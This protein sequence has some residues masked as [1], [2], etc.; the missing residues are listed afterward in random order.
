[1]GADSNVSDDTHYVDIDTESILIKQDYE[2]DTLPIPCIITIE[3]VQYEAYEQ[4]FFEFDAPGIYE[5]NVDAG[6]KYLKKDFK[7]DYQ[8]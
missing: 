7:V 2:L 3:G 8:S 1:M 5:I 4:P 6:V